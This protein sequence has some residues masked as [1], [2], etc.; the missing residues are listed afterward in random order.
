MEASLDRGCYI[1]Y[2][3][4]TYKNLTVVWLKVAASALTF[5]EILSASGLDFNSLPHIVIVNY[6]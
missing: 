1:I 3:L 2:C 4:Y 6:K 5:I